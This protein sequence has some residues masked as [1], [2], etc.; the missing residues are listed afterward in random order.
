LEAFIVIYAPPKS[1]K[2]T[3]EP[4]INH[5]GRVGHRSDR[6]MEG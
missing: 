4:C 3:P 6:G 2:H 1:P 5:Y